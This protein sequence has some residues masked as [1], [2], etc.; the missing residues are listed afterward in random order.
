LLFYFHGHDAYH[1]DYLRIYESKLLDMFDYATAIFVVSEQM[2]SPFLS[3]A[4]R[5]E[6]ILLNPYCPREHFFEAT[7]DSNGTLLAL[8]RFV[9]TKA[10]YLT[11]LAF[12]NALQQKPDT[13]FQFLGDGPLLPICRDMA[14]ALGIEGSVNFAGSVS[15]ERTLE[16]FNKATMFIQHSVTTVDGVMEGTPVAILEAAAAGLPIVST[17]HAGIPQAVLDGETGFLVEER[18]ICGM[19]E[20][21]L[22][23]LGDMQ[24]ANQFG[25]RG[26]EHIR[27]NFS[28]KDHIRRIQ[29]K[30]DE[31]LGLGLR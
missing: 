20:Y 5:P 26:R 3:L 10:S 19:T 25:N 27:R 31:C 6:T 24:L 23:L 11:L 2:R 13:I 28:Q 21:I 17:R 1:K 12:E 18:D 15:P 8:G 22:R 14:K 9:D 7:R 29:T 4:A 30:V 16:Y